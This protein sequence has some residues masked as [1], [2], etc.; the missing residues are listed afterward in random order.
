[1]EWLMS[2]IYTAVKSVVAIAVAATAI[3]LYFG[4]CGPVSSYATGTI[5]ILAAL[6]LAFDTFGMAQTLSKLRTEVDRLAIENNTFT[7]NN[8]TLSKQLFDLRGYAN[9]LNDQITAFKTTNQTLN[10]NVDFLAGEN[11]TLKVNVSSLSTNNQIL[12][13]NIVGLQNM[14]A[15]A[16]R[17]IESLKLVQAQSKLLI[18][19]LMTTS[20]D[21]KDIQSCLLS[22]LDKIEHTSDALTLIL[23]KLTSNQ[24]SA[25]DQNHDG[26]ISRDELE[27]WVRNS[28]TTKK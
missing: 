1:M 12:S 23:D 5:T 28:Q 13:Q 9:N 19:T 18:Q 8:T 15:T 10:H 7:N 26:S 2:K 17:Q 20:S 6:F 4:V 27:N 3:A 22:G 21:M 16:T 14:Q 11:S 24:F 25:I